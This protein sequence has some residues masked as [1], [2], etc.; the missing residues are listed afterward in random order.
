[1][2]TTPYKEKYIAEFVWRYQGSSK[3]SPET[4]WGFFPGLSLAY[5]ISQEE[6]WENSGMGDIINN[7]KIRGSLGKTG[8]DLIEPYQF[9]SLYQLN[10]LAFVTGDQVYHQVF[11]E[12]Q[13]GNTRAQWE[14]ARQFNVGLD[15]SFLDNRLTFT[16]DYFNNLRTKILI[17]QTAS[18]PTTT[19]MA[20]ILPDVNLGEVRNQ[21]L[22]ST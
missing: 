16:T 21:G 6:F 8:N 20:Y 3:F 11:N 2:S 19:G 14:E 22:T 12:S 5:R 15:M 10:F 17:T 1:M 13:A 4:R 7:L 9:Y 18:V